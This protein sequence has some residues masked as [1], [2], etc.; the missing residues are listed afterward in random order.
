[1]APPSVHVYSDASGSFDC[2]AFSVMAGWFQLQWPESWREVGIAVKEMLPVEA[3]AALWGRGWSGSHIAFHIDNMAA[4]AV[5]ERHAPKDT[6]LAHL[7]RCLCFYAALFRFEFSASHI[8]G[9]QNMAADALSRDNLDLF[10]L[11]YPQV[12]HSPV[13]QVIHR[14]LLHSPPDWS[15]QAWIN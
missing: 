10:S 6:T 8:A 3:A 14:L 9:Q 2:G 11:L 15:S 12:P 4:V 13:P 7:L 1:M 5:L